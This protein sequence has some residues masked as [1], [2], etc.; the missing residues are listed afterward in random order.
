M[1]YL[2][3]LNALHLELKVELTNRL[4]KRDYILEGNVLTLRKDYVKLAQPSE[5][6]HTIEE[7]IKCRIN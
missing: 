2:E 4:Y 5:L 3:K 1:S 7:A 6:E